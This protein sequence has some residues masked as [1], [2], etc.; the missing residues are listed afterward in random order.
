MHFLP[1]TI[2]AATEGAV[3][4]VAADPGIYGILIPLI[5]LL[6]ILGFAFTALFGRR[7]QARFG[8]G[9]A[10][11]VPILLVVITW[12]IAMA[13]V[14]PALTH[15]EPFGETSPSGRG[16]RPATSSWTSASTSTPSRRRC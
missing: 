9:G 13:V 2:L 12:L 15:Q 8:R 3:E 5:A 6:P 16:S 10:E 14:V 4:G 1:S 11:L 7:L